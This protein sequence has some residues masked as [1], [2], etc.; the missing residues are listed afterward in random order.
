MR[1]LR[2]RYLITVIAV[3]VLAAPLTMFAS[4]HAHANSGTTL[5]V[6]ARPATVPATYVL[7]P[8][9]Y[10]D[11]HCVYQLDPNQVLVPHGSNMAIVTISAVAAAAA[12]ATAMQT[13]TP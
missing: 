4:N 5:T 8:D 11:P 9:G 7:T 1:S 12:E 10:F 13:T 6:G 2:T 3:L